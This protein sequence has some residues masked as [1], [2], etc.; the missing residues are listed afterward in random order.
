MEVGIENRAHG[1]KERAQGS[2]ERVKP[3]NERLLNSWQRRKGD[4][5]LDRKNTIANTRGKE[6]FESTK[7]SKNS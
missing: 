5:L 1:S 7:T 4:R 3:V 6:T 2:K